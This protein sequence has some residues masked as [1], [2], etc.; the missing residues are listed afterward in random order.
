MTSGGDQANPFGSATGATG[1]DTVD[2]PVGPMVAKP[3]SQ[4]GFQGLPT[5]SGAWLPDA[6]RA[7]E[8]AALRF[9]TAVF[10]IH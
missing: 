4:L 8:R 10:L 5:S 9:V 1:S 2:A 3:F 7:R 6:A